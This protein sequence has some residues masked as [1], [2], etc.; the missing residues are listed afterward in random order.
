MPDPKRCCILGICC[1]PE[2]QAA[3]LAEWL[4][5][6]AHGKD[7]SY[8]GLAKTLLAE[9]DLA[10]KGLTAAIQKLYG[11]EFAE[12]PRKDVPNG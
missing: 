8:A 11:P 6:N 4:N 9:F 2:E 1:P 12:V 5:E 7:E 3:A 10:P